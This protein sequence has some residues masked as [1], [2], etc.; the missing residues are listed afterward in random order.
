M[1]HW[2]DIDCSKIVDKR[3]LLLN[4]FKSDPSE[5]NLKEYKN[6]SKEASNSLNKKKGEF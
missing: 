3:R 1:H 5:E 6:F 2:W 4:K